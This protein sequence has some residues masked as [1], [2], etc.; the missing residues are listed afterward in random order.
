[1]TREEKIM[2]FAKRR[3]EAIAKEKVDKEYRLSALKIEI[4][5]YM[6]KV[7]ELC[8]YARLCKEAGI[9]IGAKGYYRDHDR[10]SD[11]CFI[12]NGISHRMGFNRELSAVGFYNGG[13]N[14]DYD[15]WL[16]IGGVIWCPCNRDYSRGE[17]AEPTEIDMLKWLKNINEFETA[18]LRFIDSLV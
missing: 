5:T 6:E 2:E 1:M 14:G 12:S 7:K 11:N 8:E 10:Y 4:R 9:D 13:A 17:I 15:M 18:F 16:T 3:D